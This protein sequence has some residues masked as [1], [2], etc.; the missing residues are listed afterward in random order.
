MIAML[1]I[2]WKYINNYIVLSGR[3]TEFCSFSYAASHTYLFQ[4]HGAG[5]IMVSENF[6]TGFPAEILC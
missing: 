2:R 6:A 5:E 4:T 1:S 3:Y